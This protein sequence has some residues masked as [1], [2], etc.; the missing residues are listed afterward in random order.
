LNAEVAAAVEEAA[1]VEAE[2]DYSGVEF[3][4]EGAIGADVE[5][6]PTPEPAAPTPSPPAPAAGAI[7]GSFSYALFLTLKGR[8]RKKMKDESDVY[9]AD[10]A[11]K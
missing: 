11:T 3:V 7:A 9:L 6:P 1:P 10:I 8:L 2:D 5:V 4:E